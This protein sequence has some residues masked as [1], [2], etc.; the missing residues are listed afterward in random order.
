MILTTKALCNSSW[1]KITKYFPQKSYFRELF[2]NDFSQDGMLVK[3]SNF[4]GSFKSTLQSFQMTFRAFRQKIPLK[5]A[6]GYFFLNHNAKADLSGPG[7]R[8][9]TVAAVQIAVTICHTIVTRTFFGF[10]HD[11]P[12]RVRSCIA[13]IYFTGMAH[14]TSASWNTRS[15][16]THP[17]C[18][19]ELSFGQNYTKKSRE[20][21]NSWGCFTSN[22]IVTKSSNVCCINCHKT[23][24]DQKCLHYTRSTSWNE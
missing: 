2:W 6:Q 7:F 24:C 17:K 11:L 8:V 20:L 13:L 3:K 12:A 1:K 16:V 14:E 4:G 15:W 9:A 23:L 10:Q 18:L 21:H 19:G 5:Y 22:S